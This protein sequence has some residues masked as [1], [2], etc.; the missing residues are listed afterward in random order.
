[1]AQV[2]GNPVVFEFQIPQSIWEQFTQLSVPQEHWWNVPSEVYNYD[3]LTA[4]I[5]GLE[6]WSQVKVNPDPDVYAVFDNNITDLHFH[7]P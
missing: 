2:G 4:P 7:H 3:I 1:M 6:Q 5:S